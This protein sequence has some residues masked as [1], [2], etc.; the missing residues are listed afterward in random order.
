[1][2]GELTDLVWVT[3]N[4]EDGNRL[5]Y[6][7]PSKRTACL[8]AA[9]L[10]GNSAAADTG[11]IVLY[12][13][14]DGS[15]SVMV[16]QL[17]RAWVGPATWGDDGEVEANARLFA[18]AREMYERAVWVVRLFGTDHPKGKVELADHVA[19]LKDIIGKVEPTNRG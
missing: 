14:G 12:G 5:A 3:M 1:M 11:E 6:V 9:A 18:A 4:L 10:V 8:V 15:A 17:P 13:R 19:A 7:G 2:K 16:R